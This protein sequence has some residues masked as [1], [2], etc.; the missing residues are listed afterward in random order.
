MACS[1]IGV[2]MNNYMFKW[3][4]ISGVFGVELINSKNKYLPAIITLT[5]LLTYA[6]IVITTYSLSYPPTS[7]GTIKADVSRLSCCTDFFNL[8]DQYSNY[9]HSYINDN[10][11]C[12]YNN[13]LIPR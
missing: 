4:K 1:M 9:T 3:V 7:D 8:L 2:T 6:L 10:Y 12:T 5:L 11:R 13:R